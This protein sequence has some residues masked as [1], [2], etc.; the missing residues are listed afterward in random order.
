MTGNLWMAY[1]VLGFFIILWIGNGYYWSTKVKTE[2]DFALAGRNVGFAMGTGTVI[3][4]W[5]TANTIL[6]APEQAFTKG[7]YGIIGYSLVGI[8]VVFFAPLAQRIKDVMPKGV[9]SGEFFRLRYGKTTWSIY[10]ILS[11]AYLFAFLVTQSMG[12]GLVL[13]AVFGIPYN[14]GMV[15]ITLVCVAYTMMGGLRSVI[16]MDFINTILIMACLVIVVPITLTEIGVAELYTGVMANAP[17]RMEVLQPIGLVFIF[18][19]PVFAVGEIFHSNLWWLRAH[20]MKH[21]NV[22]KT[23]LA[24]GFIWM[25]VPVLAGMTGL[26]QLSTGAAPE[27]LNMIFP[28]MAVKALGGAGAFLVTVLVLASISSTLD[29]L[30]AGTSSLLAE[31]VYRGLINPQ[32]RDAAI[33]RVQRTMILLLGLA[34]IALAWYK[35]GTLGQILYFSGAFVCSMIWPIVYG[36]YDKT[37]S[38][39][40]ANISMILGTLAGVLTNIYISPF[41]G[42]TVAG[43]VSFVIFIAVCKAKPDDFDWNRLSGTSA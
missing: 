33:N 15:T 2:D 25:F 13:D 36:L 9:T 1:G 29:S 41:G 23:W 30:L 17:E 14:V 40:A 10:F 12:A 3:A 42:P 18:S 27:H 8:S 32:A 38:A 28:Q 11:V 6:T 37:V 26:I 24:G 34:S 20:A 35:I 39:A 5:I 19:A 4:T 7:V 16:A 43:I 31:D 21:K 22:R